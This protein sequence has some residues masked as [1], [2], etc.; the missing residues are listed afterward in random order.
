MLITKLFSLIVFVHPC[1]QMFVSVLSGPWD[2]LFGGGNIPAFIVGAVSAVVSGI[3]AFT[4]LPSPPTGALTNL[5]GG[6]G[7]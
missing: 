3:L 6:G 5:S 4:L 7:H 2:A 1:M